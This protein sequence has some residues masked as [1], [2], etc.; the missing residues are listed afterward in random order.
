MIRQKRSI[1]EGTLFGPSRALSGPQAL[2]AQQMD[3]YLRIRE[4]MDGDSSKL[5]NAIGERFISRPQT[6]YSHTMLLE[7]AGLT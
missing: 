6:Q 4:H 2:S 7:L 5:F 1:S 3:T